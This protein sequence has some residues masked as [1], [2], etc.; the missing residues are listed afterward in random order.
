MRRRLAF[1]LPSIGTV[2]FISG[3]IGGSL[4]SKTVIGYEWRLV[5][6]VYRDPW[7]LG[8]GIAFGV[9]AFA[10]SWYLSFKF[11]KDC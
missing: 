1:F 4:L 10:L 9:L 3:L 5:P 2:L 8:S 11:E 6:V 7:I